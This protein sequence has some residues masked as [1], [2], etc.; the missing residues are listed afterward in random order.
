MII[1]NTITTQAQ[2]IEH[3]IKQVHIYDE[4]SFN[5]S[6]YETAIKVLT[7]VFDMNPADVDEWVELH[8]RHYAS[9]E[10]AQA[11]LDSNESN[12]NDTEWHKM[13]T[14]LSEVYA[15]IQKLRGMDRLEKALLIGRMV[16]AAIDPSKNGIF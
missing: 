10:E 14:Q 9:H 13:L 11:W 7:W 2:K 6:L 3:E 1:N 4:L 16:E 8:S 15:D 5:G 12:N